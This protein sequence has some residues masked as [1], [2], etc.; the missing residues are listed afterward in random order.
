VHSAWLSGTFPVGVALDAAL[1][2]LEESFQFNGVPFG[3]AW[4][5]TERRAMG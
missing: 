1:G 2:F 3:A 5:A 4:L